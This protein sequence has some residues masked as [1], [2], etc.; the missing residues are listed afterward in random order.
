MAVNIRMIESV[1]VIY[2]ICPVIQHKSS[3][4]SKFHVQYSKTNF[5]KGDTKRN[6]V[7]N[8]LD[9]NNSRSNCALNTLSLSKNMSQ[10]HVTSA[11]NC[12]GKVDI[13]P[14]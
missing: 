1:N 13:H 10:Y 12:T 5:A 8:Q 9:S 3:T 14:S 2:P 11:Q 7:M 6:R 4:T